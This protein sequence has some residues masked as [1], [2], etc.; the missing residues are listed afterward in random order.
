[1]SV[2]TMMQRAR[3]AV[4]RPA[5]R[6]S[7]AAPATPEPIATGPAISYSPMLDGDPDPGEV[8]WSWVAYEDDPRQGKDRPVLVIGRDGGQLLALQ[9]TSKGGRS[10]CFE[11][12]RG[13]W[14]RENRVSYVKLDR[15]LR[16]DPDAMRREGAVI[17]RKRF[18]RVVERLEA[19]RTG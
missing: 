3:S 18:D 17:E 11:L 9:L 13:S 19:F 8:V 12:G 16:I 5:S 7:R 10:D 1:M 6:R 4:A 15:L 14:D 2:R